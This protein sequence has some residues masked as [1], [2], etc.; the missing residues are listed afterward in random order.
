MIGEQDHN[1]VYQ[2]IFLEIQR[3]FEIPLFLVTG[4]VPHAEVNN[5]TVINK[6]N[7]KFLVFILFNMMIPLAIGWSIVG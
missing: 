1:F 4:F 5:V 3:Q 6:I 7:I 2:L